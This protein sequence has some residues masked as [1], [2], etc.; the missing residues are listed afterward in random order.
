MVA[1]YKDIVESGRGDNF[2][3]RTHFEHEKD[4]PQSLSFSRGDIFKV[5]DTLYDGKLGSWLA[6]R[7]DR[8]NQLQ[9][10]GLIPSKSRCVCVCVLETHM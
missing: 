7:T 4:S 6:I 9:E 10:K 8:D 1:V 3:I 2:Y 5:I